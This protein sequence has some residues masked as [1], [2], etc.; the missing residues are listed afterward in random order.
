MWLK[1]IFKGDSRKMPL[2]EQA[3]PIFLSKKDAVRID[4]RKIDELI[5]ICKGII[6]DK[7]ITQ[8]EINFLYQWLSN[9]IGVA[10]SWSGKN[11]LSENKSS[12]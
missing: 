7:D 1:N 4:E 5:G 6:A 10:N 12:S 9:N 8:D 3:Q 11:A 2:D